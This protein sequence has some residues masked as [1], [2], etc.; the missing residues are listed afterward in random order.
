[1]RIC[2]GEGRG[3]EARLVVL[4]KP[5]AKQASSF[6]KI[7]DRTPSALRTSSLLGACLKCI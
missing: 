2:E 3:T 5:S 6:V 1:M 4:R 7:L